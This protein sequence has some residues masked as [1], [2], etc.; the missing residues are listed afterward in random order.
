[1]SDIRV[2]FEDKDIVALSKPAGVVVHHDAAHAE[3]TLVDWFLARY[4]DSQNVGDPLRPGV[5]H[6]LDKD[7]SGV[8]LFAKTNTAYHHLKKLFEEGNIKKTYIALVVGSPK[9]DSG[10]INAP[11]AR[12]TK[13]FEKRVVGGKQGREREAVTDWKVRERLV[14]SSS[15]DSYTVL[16]VR[17]R[18]GRTHQ[19]R[20]HLAYIGYPVA[21][22]KLYGGKRYMCPPGLTRQFLH[23]STL[24]FSLPSGAHLS[25][26]AGLPQDLEQALKELR[27]K[28]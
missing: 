25:V 15:R 12:S 13:H 27:L 20:S 2:L 19:I 14:P 7:T 9:N 11:I 28:N 4:P 1:M 6:R 24:E 22:D 10:A 3:G 17:P 16:E 23:A 5:V 26:E 18:T 8:L 21:C